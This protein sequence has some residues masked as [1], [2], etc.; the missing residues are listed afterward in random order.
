VKIYKKNI[1][2]E[3]IVKSLAIKTKFNISYKKKR[4]LKLFLI[5]IPFLIFVIAF[6]YVP[7]FGWVYAFYNFQPMLGAGLA[8]QQFVG[9]ANFI[10][11]WKEKD[12]LFRIVGNTL[13][14]GGLGLLFSVFP[15]LLAILLSEVRNSKFKK[16]VQTTSTFP[17]F[18]SWIVVFG[19]ATSIFSNS[20]V[21]SQIITLFGGTPPTIGLIG[22]VNNVWIFQ[23]LLNL[24]KGLGWSAIIYI[25]AITGID[26][27]LYEAAKVDGANKIQS[28]RHVTIPGIMPT[29]LV[30]FLLGIS[31]I[32]N[33]FDQYFIFYNSI[34]SDKI[35]TID[36]YT[37]QLA[38]LD[39][40]YSYSI[41]FGMVKTFVSI[42][43]LFS[44][45]ALAKRIRGENLI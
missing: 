27:E 24:W 17:N 41:A 7:L 35:T 2:G 40:Q 43:L 38:I 42:F 16:I 6:F 34:V 29:F 15:V 8:H 3:K 12:D 19:I 4:G 23:A 13:A 37:Y 28:I 32:L 10:E 44:A 5:A 11:I 30:L 36:L 26:Q 25:A 14:M 31:F 21:V 1:Q 22:D 39:G 33:G 20:G 18:I 45:N 9:F